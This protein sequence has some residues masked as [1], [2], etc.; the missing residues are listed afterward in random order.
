MTVD[1]INTKIGIAATICGMSIRERM[2][3]ETKIQLNKT[4]RTAGRIRKGRCR[5]EN[6]QRNMQ[7]SPMYRVCL[8][9]N[10]AG[11]KT[12]STIIVTNVLQNPYPGENNHAKQSKYCDRVQIREIRL[13]TGSRAIAT[14]IKCH[15]AN[16]HSKKQFTTYK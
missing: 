12:P 10:A 7:T 8:S 3:R 14:D 6:Y 5:L 13:S 4:N 9:P 15:R 11:I 1:S 2:G 16:Y